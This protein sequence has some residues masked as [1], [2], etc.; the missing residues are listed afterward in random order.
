MLQEEA[1]IRGTVVDERGNPL[2]GM[3]IIPQFEI[4]EP[5]REVEAVSDARGRFEL[6]GMFPG[7]SL[8][9]VVREIEIINSPVP[10]ITLTAGDIIEDL[11]LVCQVGSEVI[12]GIVVDKHGET[13]PWA[14]VECSGINSKSVQSDVQGRFSFEGL[15]PGYYRIQA[16][17]SGYRGVELADVNAGSHN[18][19]IILPDPFRVGRRPCGCA[20]P[21]S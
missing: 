8:M 9:R 2:E 3:R 17:R 12:A 5:R 20:G 10:R 18:V 7:T 21:R 6:A 13:V 1:I 11:A 16:R 4:S 19:R 14:R 15:S